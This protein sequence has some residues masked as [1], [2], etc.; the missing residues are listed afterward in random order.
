M[1]SV[2]KTFSIVEGTHIEGDKGLAKPLIVGAAMAVVANPWHGQ[3]FVDDLLPKIKLLAPQTADILVELL[4]KAMG[5][6]A[7][8]IE[9][10]G[11]AVVAGSDV[12]IEHASALIHTLRFG[13][14]FRD[15]V[16]G[17]SVISSS[18]VRGGPG[19]IV[20]IPMVHKNNET[21]R[22][23][24]MTFQACIPDAP[25]SSEIIVAIAA[26][27][28]GRPHARLGNRQMDIAEGY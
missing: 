3:G 8:N 20:T 24:Y 21:E 22:S 23:H 12:E 6:D 11:K 16:G 28:G 26:A 9:A 7:S 14:K 5:E 17:S 18:N 25:R 27:T 13:N 15:A 19:S 10:I 2:R 1:L 4:F